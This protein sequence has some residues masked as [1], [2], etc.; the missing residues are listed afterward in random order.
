MKR[1]VITAGASGIGKAMAEAF[2]ARGDAVALCDV[3]EAALAAF[4]ERHPEALALRADVSREAE[5][6]AF[7]AAVERDWGAGPEVVCANAGTGGEAGGIETLDYEA[8]RA[9]I[10]VN[11]DGAF[12]TARRAV[13]GMKAARDG[14]IVF[15]SSSAGLL[16]YPYRTPYAAAKWAVIGLTKSLAIELGPHGIRVNALCPGSVVGERM[17][18]VIAREA[19]A[20]GRPVAE[21]RAGYVEGVS[22]RR[23]IE[24]EEIAAMA[25]YLS[26]PMGRKISGQA[27]SI[28]GHTETLSS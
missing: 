27:I 12:L 10:G 14:L 21:V 5:V 4:R 16:G 6:E 19:A 15:T 20:R 11:L 3:D 18:R 17:E 28:D 1:V 26:S 9:C 2:I 22:L 8:W 25:L 13:R 23:W 24:P 7:F